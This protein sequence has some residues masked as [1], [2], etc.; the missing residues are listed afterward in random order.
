V[1]WM[2][3]TVGGPRVRP[4]GVSFEDSERGV[5]TLRLSRVSLFPPKILD[6]LESTFSGFSAWSSI[7]QLVVVTAATEGS[8]TNG[9]LQDLC[10]EHPRELTSR[11]GALVER[12]V[13]RRHGD[14]RGTWYTV[15][16]ESLTRQLAIDFYDPGPAQRSGNSSQSS[17]SS[18]QSS[19]S[20][21]QS[22]ESSSQSSENSS[23]SSAR[24]SLGVVGSLH[25]SPSAGSS[26]HGPTNSSQNFSDLSQTSTSTSLRS[27]SDSLLLLRGVA[28]SKWARREDIEQAIAIL[29]DGAFLTADEIAEE[30]RRRRATIVNN[31][32]KPMVRAGR[33]VA[34][35]PRQ[36]THPKQRYRTAPT[37]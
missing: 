5:T 30:L 21:S 13:L 24:S 27:Q 20:S 25:A 3:S 35:F 11:L 2:V 37:S 34:E 36:P 8:V 23:Q 32:L 19:E 17:E 9:R 15:S 6:A 4:L 33:L 1:L 16:D 26:R 28:S 12:A 22:S 10:D 18:S 29:C 31:Y 14:R 7:D